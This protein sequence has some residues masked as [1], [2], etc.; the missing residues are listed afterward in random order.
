M[1]STS[2]AQEHFVLHSDFFSVKLIMISSF[3]QSREKKN[4][5]FQPEWSKQRR[6]H[7]KA[8]ENAGNTL[9]GEMTLS[10]LQANS[11]LWYKVS[12]F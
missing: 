9:K 8:V 2:T 12:T 6:L 3:V 11:E 4:I 10:I 1:T 7:S 5:P